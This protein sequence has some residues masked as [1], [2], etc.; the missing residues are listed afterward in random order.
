MESQESWQLNYHHHLC[1]KNKSPHPAPKLKNC[2]QKT[3]P[4]RFHENW[5]YT[6]NALIK[7]SYSGLHLLTAN[8]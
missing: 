8:E 3:E 7:H 6:E 1:W 5:S 2:G 4:D